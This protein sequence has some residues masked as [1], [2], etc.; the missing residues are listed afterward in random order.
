M[1]AVLG[2][3]KLIVFLLCLLPVHGALALELTGEPVQGG[4][5][6]GK[7][8]PGS[9]VRL[10]QQ[11]IMVSPEGLFV[12]GFGRDE[13]GQR[14]LTVT[15]PDGGQTTQTLVIAAREYKIERVDGLPPRTV[16]PDPEAM[17]RIRQEAA[18][19]SNARSRR[20][21]RTDYAAGFEWPA[22]GRISGVYGSQRVLNGEPRRP[23]AS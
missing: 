19:V 7:A 4:I 10:D 3:Q 16:T 15:R 18:M 9:H 14:T 6:F 2:R 20:D 23:M 21:T 8:E 17:E 5:L 11:D 1:P 13:S 12:L 22:P